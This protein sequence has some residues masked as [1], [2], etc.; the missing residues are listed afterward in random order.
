MIATERSDIPHPVVAFSREA[1]AQFGG[2][3][4]WHRL[5]QA[6]LNKTFTHNHRLHTPTKAPLRQIVRHRQNVQSA[7]VQVFDAG[8]E[9]DCFVLVEG[10]AE[11]EAGHSGG[12]RLRGH[13]FTC[14][15]GRVQRGSNTGSTDTDGAGLKIASTVNILIFNAVSSCRDSVLHAEAGL[16]HVG[17][18]YHC[19]VRLAGGNKHGCWARTIC[20]RELTH[21]STS[22][23]ITKLHQG[24]F[25]SHPA[26]VGIAVGRA[27]EH[28][29]LQAFDVN[30]LVGQSK[31]K[32]QPTLVLHPSQG[33]QDDSAGVGQPVLTGCRSSP[34]RTCPDR[35]RLG[36]VRRTH[37]IETS[38]DLPGSADSDPDAPELAVVSLVC[39]VAAQGYPC[40]VPCAVRLAGIGTRQYLLLNTNFILAFRHLQAPALALN[41]CRLV[42]QNCWRPKSLPR[43]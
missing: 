33:L 25:R 10:L 11:V 18:V 7:V 8:P 1:Q 13:T 38:R 41:L 27:V 12:M 22:H 28:E 24:D 9:A 32:L 26:V 39:L 4:R 43:G 20:P 2:A 40:K 16:G 30:V 14:D 21:T 29:S 3:E 31:T 42:A 17:H 36:A 37:R 19:A 5:T 15:P 35:Y 23:L 6:N 34:S